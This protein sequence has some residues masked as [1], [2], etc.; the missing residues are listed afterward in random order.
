MSHEF[1]NEMETEIQTRQLR[2]TK[3]N[4]LVFFLLRRYRPLR[5]LVLLVLNFRALSINLL[6]QSNYANVC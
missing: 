2:N 3:Q 6:V 1:G 4:Y 5:V